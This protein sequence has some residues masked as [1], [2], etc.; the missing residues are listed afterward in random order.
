MEVEFRDSD[1]RR[2]ESDA[3]FT[4]GLSPALVKAFRRRLQFIR[5]APDER[6]LYQM[7]SLHFERLKGNR[8]HQ[9]S[10]R[11]NDQ[12]RLI[13]EIQGRDRTRKLI[14]VEITDYH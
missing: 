5:A 14:V 11:L 8:R 13:V 12:F 9:R 1:L 6:D 2:L 3:R 7:R 10:I 4:A